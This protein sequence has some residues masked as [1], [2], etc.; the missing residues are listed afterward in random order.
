MAGERARYPRVFVRVVPDRDTDAS[1]DG[2]ASSNDVLI[3]RLLLRQERVGL[4]EGH[5][6]VEL[7]DGHFDTKSCE[8][9]E[10][11]LQAGGDL[12]NDEMT[13]EANAVDGYA[14]GLEGLHEVQHRCG[15]RACVLEVVLVDVQL[16]IGICGTSGLEGSSNVGGA[17]RVIEDVGPP[18]AV[19][20]ERLCRDR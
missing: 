15:L 9:L 3:V 7:R 13:L 1:R 16:G 14:I 20:G 17:E 10:L 4:G 11:G 6:D 2:V 5:A 12:P 19:V 18:G 8:S